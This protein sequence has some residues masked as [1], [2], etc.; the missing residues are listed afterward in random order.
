MAS[1]HFLEH[2]GISWGLEEKAEGPGDVFAE[3]PRAESRY[4]GY[5]GV[6]YTRILSQ[7]TKKARDGGE[8]RMERRGLGRQ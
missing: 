7:L 8:F 4:S 2:L 6:I 3:G 1:L 5:E